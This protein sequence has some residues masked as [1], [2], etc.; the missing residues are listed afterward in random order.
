MSSEESVGVE[1]CKVR[2]K[3]GSRPED[4]HHCGNALPCLDHPDGLPHVPVSTAKKYP[5][6]PDNRLPNAVANVFDKKEALETRLANLAKE[7]EEVRTRLE[8]QEVAGSALDFAQKVAFALNTAGQIVALQV[9]HTGRSHDDGNAIVRSYWLDP[10][11]PKDA[12]I[13]ERLI[14]AIV[15]EHGG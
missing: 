6:P 3:D 8:A 12:R 9:R 15:E 5:D 1:R 11:N 7:V 10:S 2:L 13:L 14:D 4:W